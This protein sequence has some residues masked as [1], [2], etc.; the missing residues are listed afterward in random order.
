V[1]KLLKSVQINKLDK[2]EGQEV[3]GYYEALE[4]I[5]EHH[6]DIEISER[7]LYP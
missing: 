5:L 2:R 1:K 4:L 3:V 7:Y 6:P